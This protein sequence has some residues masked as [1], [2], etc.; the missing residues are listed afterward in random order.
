LREE[1]TIVHGVK[2]RQTREAITREPRRP[3]SLVTLRDV[4][5]QAGVSISTVSRILNG[6]EPGVPIREETRARILAAAAELG[7]RPNLMARAL[8]G[9]PSSLLGVIVRDIADPFHIQVLQGIDQVARDRDYRLFLGHVDY[10]PELAAAYGSMFEQSHADGLIV[11][12][13]L[14]GGDATLDALAGHHRYVVGV[15][16]RVARR[17]MAGVYSDSVVGTRLALDHLWD[18]GHRRILCVADERTADGRLRADE[19]RRYLRERGATDGPRVF[20]TTQPDPEPSY[21]LGRE[22]FGH[23]D[24]PNRP[25]AIYAASDTMAIGL[26]QA[27]FQARVAVPERVSIVGFDDI[28]AAA[29]TIPPLTTISQSGL[30]MGRIAANLLLDMIE[31]DQPASEVEDVIL[32]PRLVVRQ[33]TAPAPE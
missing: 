24:R 9:S 19:Y 23:F 13:D 3:S 7:Y 29:F 11:V 5:Q 25:T 27:A 15:T 1:D 21:Q 10:R 16:D 6:R 12:G 4:A 31:K 26:L 18:L 30:E 33:S 8:R 2:D 22:L 28:D 20:F 14:K 32:A 17:R